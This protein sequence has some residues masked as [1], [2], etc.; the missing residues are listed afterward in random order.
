M[1]LEPVPGCPNFAC[2]W[3]SIQAIQIAKGAP[4]KKI[5]DVGL[6]V[7]S[8]FEE[9]DIILYVPSMIEFKINRC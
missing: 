4:Y 1:M 9:G 5:R 3:Q 6:R 7:Y 2:A 8:Q